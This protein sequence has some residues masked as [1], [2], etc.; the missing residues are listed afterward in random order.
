MDR[1]CKVFETQP[2]A[3]IDGLQRILKMETTAQHPNGRFTPEAK[4]N[5]VNSFRRP[6]N[7]FPVLPD[8]AIQAKSNICKTTPRQNTNRGSGTRETEFSDILAA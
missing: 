1:Y 6:K 2:D 8:S 7:V 4:T 5:R 3:K